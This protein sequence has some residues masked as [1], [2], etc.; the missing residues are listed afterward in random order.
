MT[1]GPETNSTKR[2]T[3]SVKC[4]ACGRDNHPLWDRKYDG[5]CLDCANAGAMEW[6]DEKAALLAERDHLAKFKA[7]VHKRLDDA[8]VPHH[9]PGPHG[10]EGCR[11]GDRLDWV[12]AALAREKG[13]A[14]TLEYIRD[15]YDHDSDAHKYGTPCRKC[16]AGEALE[17]A[18]TSTGEADGWRPIATAP[19]DGT[20]ILALVPGT[21]PV[22]GKSF[23]P[24]V[25]YWDQG[26]VTCETCD[27][28]GDDSDMAYAPRFWMPLP[29]APAD[30]PTRKD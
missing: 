26:W 1:S 15:N 25:A 4:K 8:D 21:H 20:S 11:I 17:A 29:P 6:E 12:A 14:E 30:T 27:V 23:I 3:D 19:K 16:D 28:S 5:H 10:A 22:T 18:A 24:D 13:L 7:Y 9:P 2:A